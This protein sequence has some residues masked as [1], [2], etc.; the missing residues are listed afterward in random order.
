MGK[1][2]IRMHVLRLFADRYEQYRKDFGYYP[3]DTSEVMVPVKH[4]RM[5]HEIVE[6]NDKQQI[7]KEK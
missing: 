3:N 6:E 2:M 1:A 4:L 5:A 7:G